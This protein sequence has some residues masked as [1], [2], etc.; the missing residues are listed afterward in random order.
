MAHFADLIGCLKNLSSGDFGWPGERAEK[1]EYDKKELLFYQKFGLQKSSNSWVE[2]SLS[3]FYQSLDFLCILMGLRFARSKSW[4]NFR[5]LNEMLFTSVINAV[6]MR[7]YV[8]FY[9]IFY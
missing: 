4:I 2:N 6:K 8:I 1:A 7:F 3:L 5:M 9:L